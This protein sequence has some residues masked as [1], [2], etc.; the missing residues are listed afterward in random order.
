M[1]ACCELCI[2]YVYVVRRHDDMQWQALAE[3]ICAY[4][5][6]VFYVKSVY[7]CHS[8]SVCA[9][10]ALCTWECA[11]VSLCAYVFSLSELMLYLRAWR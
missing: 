5:V 2:C 3:H 1:Y 8:V 4:S 10:C 9:K 11:S 7:V 6:C